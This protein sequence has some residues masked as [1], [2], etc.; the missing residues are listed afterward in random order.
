MYTATR[1]PTLATLALLVLGF[2]SAA[3][4]ED[5]RIRGT[6]EA[7]V[8]P[9]GLDSNGDGEGSFFVPS[10]GRT[11]FGAAT[12]E[13]WVEALPWDGAT[14][15][16]PTHV[17]INYRFLESTLRVKDGSR[18]FMVLSSGAL[19]FDY[20]N[21]SFAAAGESR[22]TGGTGRFAGATGTVSWEANTIAAGFSNGLGVLS[23]TIEGTIRVP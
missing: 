4:S 15:C 9:T 22:V 12:R 18:L 16:G 17:Q 8:H 21:G 7:T 5:I 10:Q 23:E 20:V 3:H 13:G 19:C 1:N 2:A 14:F 6:F 11:N